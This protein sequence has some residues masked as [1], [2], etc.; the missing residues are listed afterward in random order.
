M[1]SKPQQGSS[2]TW[3]SV[4][5]DIDKQQCLIDNCDYERGE[6]PRDS[7]LDM[8]K[9]KNIEEHFINDRQNYDMVRACPDP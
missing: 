1:Y 3:D 8:K 5:Q 4:F 6:R 7:K 9:K 2:Q